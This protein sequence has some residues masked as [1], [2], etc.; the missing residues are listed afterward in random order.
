[1]SDKKDNSVSSEVESRLEELFTED[2]DADDDNFN[3][4]ASPADERL[5]DLKAVVLSI[6]WEITTR[7]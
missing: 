1:M 3:D 2:G 5:R 4:M 6:D 7:P